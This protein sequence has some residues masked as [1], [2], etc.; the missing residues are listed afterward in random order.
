MCFDGKRNLL[1]ALIQEEMGHLGQSNDLFLM[2][3]SS[4]D[5]ELKFL[6]LTEAKFLSGGHEEFANEDTV[7][8]LVT[9]ICSSGVE[10]HLCCTEF[11]LSSV[12]SEVFPLLLTP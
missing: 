5:F 1:E 3:G 12:I 4:Y 7:G 10:S 2:M 11:P 9:G 8:T 6:I